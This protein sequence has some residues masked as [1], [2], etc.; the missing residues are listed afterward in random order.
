MKILYIAT[1]IE[2][3]TSFHLPYLK[4]FKEQKWEVHVAANIKTAK[5]K[6]IKYCDKTHDIAICRSPFK[7]DNI[8]AYFQLKNILKEEKFDIINSHTPMGGILARLCGKIHRKSGTKILY[9]AHGFHFYKG[10]PFINWLLYYPVEKLLSKYT[11]A[12]ITL[13]HEDYALARS[14]MQA[15]NIYYIP[16]IGIDINK[17]SKPDI[18][19][20]I[21]RKELNIPSDAAVI[22]SIGELSKRKNHLAAIKALGKIKSEKIYYIICGEGRLKESLIKLCKD[23]GVGNRVMF[24]GYRTDT[25]DLLHM[26]DI[27]LFPSKQEGLPVALMEA[28]AA[29]LPCVVSEIRGNVDLISDSKGGY[30]CGVND[31]ESYA[32]AVVQLVKSQNLRFGMGEYNKAVIKDFDISVVMERMFK[33]YGETGKFE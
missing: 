13:N 26:S 15:E 1:V 32:N 8:K 28:M 14:K 18:V 30:L 7:F 33:I 23:S 21:K 11:D 20:E 24:L 31:V 27:F 25:A 3:I 16:G 17:F 10:A 4:W 2:H 29:G 22:I 5:N 19:R 9:T 12:L 6:N